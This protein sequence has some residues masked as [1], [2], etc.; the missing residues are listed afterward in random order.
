MRRKTDAGLE[1]GVAEYPYAAAS[2]EE[3]GVLRAF[4]ERVESGRVIIPRSIVRFGHEPVR[5]RRT[6]YSLVGDGVNHLLKLSSRHGAERTYFGTLVGRIAQAAVSQQS[7]RFQ[8]AQ[9]AAARREHGQEQ[10]LVDTAARDL[11]L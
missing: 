3:T 10:A 7:A 5:I 2:E 8:A 1:L 6:T 11:G 4:A 9:V